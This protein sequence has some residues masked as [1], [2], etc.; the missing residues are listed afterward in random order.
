[1][2]LMT[3]FLRSEANFSFLA[4]GIAMSLMSVPMVCSPALITLLADKNVDPRRILAVSFSLSSCVLTGIFFSEHV[5]LTLGLFLLHGLS[6]VAML[7]LQ[8]GFYF[9]YAEENRKEDIKVTPYPLV[10]IWGT[11]GFIV[12]SLILF[13]PLSKSASPGVIIPCAVAFCL[14]SIANS[15]TLPKLKRLDK[16]PVDL[17]RKQR[18]PTGK[19]FATLFSP[20]ARWLCIGLAI[21]FLATSSYYGF[22]ANYYMEVVE[23][24]NKYIG[25]IINFGVLLEIGYTL[26]M[27]KLQKWISLKGILI[28]GLTL[29]T[30][31]MFLLWA[32]PSVGMVIATQ[33]GHGL[34]VLALFVVPVMFLNRL[35]GDEFRNSIQG[36][37]TMS[38]S[39]VSR[40]IGGVTAGWITMTFGLRELFL[41]TGCLGVVATLII[42]FL[43]AR[44]P[45]P[46]DE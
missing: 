9:S 35:A 38:V 6:F 41:V 30:S 31:R 32:F 33:I 37:Y 26:L 16:A 14:L 19:A 46:P 44:I 21:A 40:V 43:F 4:I 12:P 15:F 25:L 10:R 2:P 34:E 20:E 11:I 28:G 24:P 27:P 39:G 3:I 22:I 7:P 17:T 5:G 23:L 1:M 29:M 8:D 13:Y 45:P 18:L 42:T 36:V